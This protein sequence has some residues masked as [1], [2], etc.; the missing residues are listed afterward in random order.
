MIEKA[1]KD[2]ATLASQEKVSVRLA[3]R[4]GGVSPSGY[5]A[6]RTRGMSPRSRSDEELKVKVLKLHRDSRGT[7]GEPRI[8]A[9]LRQEGISC[10]KSR[11]VRLMKEAGIA[12]IGRLRFKVATT[13]SNHAL[14][15]APRLFQTENPQTLPTG[16]HQIWASDITYIPTDEGWLFL[17][18][19]LD[20]F[21]RKIVGHAME[22]H[23]RAELVLEALN[24][25]LSGSDLRG[26]PLTAHS[27]RGSQYACEAVSERLKLL[28]I[29]ASMSRKGNCYD[30][31][32]AESFFHTLKNEL[33][34]RRRYKTRKEAMIEIFDYI[35]GWY[36][37]RRL[38]SSLGYQTPN[39]YE[40]QSLLAA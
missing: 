2:R 9:G 29:R 13:D 1:L 23:M 24:R 27:D 40:Q 10:G 16:P 5:Y 11:I 14:P 36:N 26:G 19:F 20:V 22:D 8:R 39:D 25:A 18:I 4:L 37:R 34:H 31:A 35:E 33:V 32:F 15:V 28:G 3:C 7:Y 17:A 12:G 6:W 38:H 30:N 21:T